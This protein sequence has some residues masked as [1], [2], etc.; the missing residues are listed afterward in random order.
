MCHSAGGWLGRAFLADPKYRG[1]MFAAGPGAGGAAGT[2]SLSSINEE[3]M[4]STG[5]TSS[6]GSTDDVGSTSKT[7]VGLPSLPPLLLTLPQPTAVAGG[8]GK[9]STGGT[10]GGRAALSPNPVVGALVTL[11]T[12]QRPPP[13]ELMKDMTGGAQ[14]W[15]HATYPGEHYCLVV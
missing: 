3:D 12:P 9:G 13:P 1:L 5:G 4:G 14:A 6:T 8:T 10:G 15:V 11:G 7:T 2:G